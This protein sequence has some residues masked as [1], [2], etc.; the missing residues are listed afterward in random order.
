MIHAEVLLPVAGALHQISNGSLACAET[1]HT[2]IRVKTDP[3]ERPMVSQ[4]LK[5]SLYHPKLRALHV[6]RQRLRR[7]TDDLDEPVDSDLRTGSVRVDRRPRREVCY[8]LTGNGLIRPGAA[9]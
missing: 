4:C 5:R 7:S 3:N 1:L 6:N 9:E 2:K 8:G